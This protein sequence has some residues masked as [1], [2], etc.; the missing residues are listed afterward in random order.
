[1]KTIFTLKEFYEAVEKVAAQYNE[2][3]FHVE[4]Q[5]HSI[6][7][8]ELTAY[9]NGFGFHKGKSIDEIVAKLTAVKTPPIAPDV[10]V[11]IEMPVQEALTVSIYDGQTYE[12][13]ND[14]LLM[15]R[16]EQ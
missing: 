13:L 9:I 4:S 1:M 11:E 7:G 10:D 3:F 5:L 2:T 14:A 12:E 15:S 16:V 6:Y 8:V